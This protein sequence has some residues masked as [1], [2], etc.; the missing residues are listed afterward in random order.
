MRIS[1]GVK[2]ILNCVCRTEVNI[3]KSSLIGKR[4]TQVI[5]RDCADTV[6]AV[7]VRQQVGAVNGLP[8]PDHRYI[9]IVDIRQ[10]C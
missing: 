2:H 7:Q 10:G 4:D 3:N 9:V 8:F 6:S 1:D 5:A